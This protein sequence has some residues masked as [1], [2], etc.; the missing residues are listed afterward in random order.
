ME[1]LIICG[2]RNSGK[3]Q[4]FD[5]L[6]EA[7]RMPVY[8]FV[9]DIVHTREDG[10]HEIYMF[11]VGE[12]E[13]ILSEENHVGDCNMTE[14]TVHPEVFDNLGLELLQT[15]TDG[16]VAMDELGFMETQSPR[17]CSRVLELLDGDTPV[18]ATAKKSGPDMEFLS[19]IH[20]HPKVRICEV[21]AENREELC[22]ELLGVIEDWNRWFG[23]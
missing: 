13:R 5:R 12:R 3:T 20:Q 1:H 21:T 7:C 19:R 14:R 6:L 15:G 23:C 4:V 11:P 16:I 22:E 9:T 2:R 18:L 17:F 10:Y 8:G